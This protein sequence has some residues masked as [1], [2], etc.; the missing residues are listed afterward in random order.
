MFHFLQS[1]LYDLKGTLRFG[2]SSKKIDAM[3]GRSSGI[4]ATLWRWCRL[5]RRQRWM[6][7]HLYSSVRQSTVMMP[8]SSAMRQA[9]C[10]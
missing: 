4:H 5:R 6:A 3:H 8:L 9:A 10:H 1:N 7:V 2:Y